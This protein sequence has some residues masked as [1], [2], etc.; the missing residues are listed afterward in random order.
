MHRIDQLFGLAKDFYNHGDPGHDLAHVKRVMENCQFLAQFEKADLEPLMAAAMLHDVIN[1]PKNHPERAKAS[2]MAANKSAELLSTVGFDKSEV[3]RIQAIITEHSYSLGKAPSSIESA[4]LQDADRLDGL[5][6]LGIMR[7][8]SCGCLMGARYYHPEDPFANSRA[9]DDKSFTLDHFFNK[10]FKLPDL[11]NTDA[12][13]V[14][15]HRRVR[16]MKEFLTELKIE[17]RH[18]GQPLEQAH[19]I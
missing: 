9:L 2:E 17:L 14:E 3:L 10:L 4:L 13:R 6:A 7:T 1:V 19:R 5:G 16:F 8:V 18:E 12:A 11:M 15:G